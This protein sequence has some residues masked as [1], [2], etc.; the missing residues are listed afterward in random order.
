MGKTCDYNLI[1]FWEMEVM[2]EIARR[3]SSPD[4]SPVTPPSPRRR[5][6]ALRSVVHEDL[7]SVQTI[8]GNGDCFFYSIALIYLKRVSHYFLEEPDSVVLAAMRFFR[9]SVATTIH[10]TPELL[11]IVRIIDRNVG[12]MLI[13][14]SGSPNKHDFMKYYLETHPY[15]DHYDISVIRKLPMFSDTVFVIYNSNID[16]TISFVCDM[17]IPRNAVY[18]ALLRR[19]QEHYEPI[20]FYC[21]GAWT[22]RLPMDE[23]QFREFGCL[24]RLIYK[25]CPAFRSMFQSTM[26]LHRRVAVRA[27]TMQ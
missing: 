23:I 5:D 17:H 11:E 2:R 10:K 15:A 4:S 25:Q 14:N 22:H 9:R 8:P 20:V 6:E 18:I 27:T 12:K 1:F 19:C 16:N 24:F 3:V 13:D 21:R 7:Y 26:F